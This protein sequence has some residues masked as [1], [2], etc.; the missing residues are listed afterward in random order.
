MSTG[1]KRFSQAEMKRQAK[2]ENLRVS[3]N[4]LKMLSSDEYGELAD[5]SLAFQIAKDITVSLRPSGDGA[6]TI[7]P[8]SA[9][10]AMELIAYC[11]DAADEES[12][13]LSEAAIKELVHKHKTTRVKDGKKTKVQVNA[14]KDAVKVLKLLDAAHIPAFVDM[15]IKLMEQ[16]KRSTLQGKDVRPLYDNRDKCAK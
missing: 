12:G 13:R 16:K 4:V 14:S 10:V 15:G 11:R 9:E 1:K 8:Y 2:A 7:Q 5:R 6:T 3:G